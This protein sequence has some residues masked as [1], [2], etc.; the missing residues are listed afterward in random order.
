MTAPLLVS[1]IARVTGIVD[2]SAGPNTDGAPVSEATAVGTH[3]SGTAMNQHQITAEIDRLR[4]ALAGMR[5][6]VEEAL[7]R[8]EE[9]AASLQMLE[10]T[11]LVNGVPGPASPPEPTPPGADSAAR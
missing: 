4:S 3:H 1:R 9:L 6:D 5:P 10:G 11:L 2:Q 7:K 8:S